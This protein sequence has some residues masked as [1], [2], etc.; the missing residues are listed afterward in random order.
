MEFHSDRSVSGPVLPCLS[1]LTLIIFVSALPLHGSGDISLKS[2]HISNGTQAF[3][4]PFF[5]RQK[6]IAC[7]LQDDFP[8]W[9]MKN[10]SFHMS[11]Y[12]DVTGTGELSG[13]RRQ[14]MLVLCPEQLVLS[15][16]LLYLLAIL[17]YLNV[18][19]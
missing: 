18:C 13:I 10:G 3:S 5:V 14:L 8:S 9:L 11:L 7:S 15:T 12:Q 1:I 16:S 6:A 4:F 19:C 2:L 17:H